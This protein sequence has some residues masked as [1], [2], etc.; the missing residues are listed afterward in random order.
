[1][2]IHGRIRLGEAVFDLAINHLFTGHRQ[3]LIHVVLIEHDFS[4]GRAA[5]QMDVDILRPQRIAQ[6]FG[7]FAPF[8]VQLFVIQH[9]D[10]GLIALGGQ[11]INL[12]Q[13]MTQL[14]V[15]AYPFN[16]QRH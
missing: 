16:H 1:M 10:D 3:A 9:R 8:V 2:H 6:D 12:E 7:F 14:R 4:F 15:S 5:N 11:V 13:F